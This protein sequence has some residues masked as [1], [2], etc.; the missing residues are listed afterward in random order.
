MCVCVCVC[1]CV[2]AKLLQVSDL[3]NLHVLH[4]PHWQAGSLP[5]VPPGKPLVQLLSHVQLFATPWTAARQASLSITISWSLLKLISLELGMP[6][7]HLILC[8]PLLLLP[9]CLFK[10]VIVAD[11]VVSHLYSYRSCQFRKLSLALRFCS[12]L[13]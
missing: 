11:T 7:N 6:S 4:L 10:Y 1:V 5:L 3:P 8:C 13:K 12:V 9:L 2:C